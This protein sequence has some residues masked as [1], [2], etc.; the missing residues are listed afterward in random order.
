MA[1]SDEKKIKATATL[2][3]DGKP[4]SSVTDSAL[5]LGAENARLRAEVQRLAQ[6]LV[7]ADQ[8]MEREAPAY[9]RVR[10]RVR[11][12]E[13]EL[14]AT[15]NRMLDLE[16][17]VLEFTRGYRPMMEE[18]IQ[19]ARSRRTGGAVF[20]GTFSTN[21]DPPVSLGDI[22]RAMEVVRN[23]YGAPPTLEPFHIP[24]PGEQSQQRYEDGWNR[25]FRRERDAA[26]SESYCLGCGDLAADGP[27]PRCGIT[28]RT[29]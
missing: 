26:M 5:N 19:R 25:I 16:W 12:L 8:A 24:T 1:M 20:D 11:M 4:Y 28:E 17:V 27:C 6:Q 13:R 15:R 9:L 23:N 3:I 7:E 29:T 2:V 21:T 10:R 22:E 14:A 18:H